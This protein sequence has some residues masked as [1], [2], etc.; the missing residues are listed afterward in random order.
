M[1]EMESHQNQPKQVT[2]HYIETKSKKNT[3]KMDIY[4]SLLGMG[5]GTNSEAVIISP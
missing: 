1:A 4:I 3:T 2:N 5:Y